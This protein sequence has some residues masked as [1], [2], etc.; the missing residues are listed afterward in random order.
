MSVNFYETARLYIPGNRTLYSGS[1]LFSLSLIHLITDRIVQFTVRFVINKTML[2]CFSERSFQQ[3]GDRYRSVYSICPICYG[4]KVTSSSVSDV[5]IHV[6]IRKSLD[7][8]FSIVI[9]R[10]G[11]HMPVGN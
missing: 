5:D 8:V 2:H 10:Y 7:L 9:D 4:N 1:L 3:L 11:I 6:I